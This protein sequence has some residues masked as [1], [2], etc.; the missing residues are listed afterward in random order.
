MIDLKKEKFEPWK[1]SLSYQ[2]LDDVLGIKIDPS[3]VTKILSK[4]NLNPKK[5]K[6]GIICTIPTYRGDLRIEEDLIEEVARIYGYNKF[7]KTLPVG[8][9]NPLKIPYFFD[10]SFHKKLR[11]IMTASGYSE[12][13]TLSLLSKSTLDKFDINSK[14][15]VK[16]TNPVSLEYA[17]MRPSL[18]PTIIEAIK[19]NE[20]DV[21]IF[22][23]D[24][25]YPDESYKL[26][27][28]ASGTPFRKFKGVIDLILEKLDIEEFEIEFET[29]KNYFHP[30][31]S[32]TIKIGKETV[33]EFGEL[34]P[35]VLSALEIKE[36]LLCF[37][38][39]VA[40]L[41]KHAK[42]KNYVA[43]AENPAQV[44]DLTLIFPPKTRIGEVTKIFA[45]NPLVR[46]Y[47]LSGTYMGNS[48][49]FRIWYQDPKKN[50]TGKEVEEV[51]NKILKE[52]KN[53]FGGK[54]KD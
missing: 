15:S 8:Q 41:Q 46:G 43:I 19:I 39:D 34:S 52:V 21:Q 12:A 33:G 22:E 4:L 54:V 14:N 37:E 27:A 29:D 1:L 6:A 31:K 13:M 23:I 17:Y 25:V 45:S 10:G 51:R 11:K 32:G 9:V 3:E 20:G 30:S 47:E 42:S 44:E 5:S 49:T 53:K 36:T 48:Y 2:N 7:P 50:I 40:T 26:A 18:I 16:I 28:V 35:I 24:K 38:F